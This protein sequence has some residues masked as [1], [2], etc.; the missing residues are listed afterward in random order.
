MR[1]PLSVFHP[2][3]VEGERLTITRSGKPVAEIR[4]LGREPLSLGVAMSRR[5]SLPLLDPDRL[6]QDLDEIL[7]PA[8]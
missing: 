4:P 3:T 2:S 5:R 7:D 8:L 6:R 1:V